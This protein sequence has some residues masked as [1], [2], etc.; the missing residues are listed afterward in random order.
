MVGWRGTVVGRDYLPE[1]SPGS[2]PGSLARQC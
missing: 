1:V 2:E